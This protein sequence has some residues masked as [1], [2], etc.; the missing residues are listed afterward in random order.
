MP[1]SLA[2]PLQ[3]LLT[4]VHF[5]EYH[6]VQRSGLEPNN[7]LNCEQNYLIRSSQC[8]QA[9][10]HERQSC[11]SKKHPNQQVTIKTILGKH[12]FFLKCL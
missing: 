7:K 8:E 6:E 9:Y 11:L 5:L 1:P 10:C 12:L 2:T 4:F 3:A